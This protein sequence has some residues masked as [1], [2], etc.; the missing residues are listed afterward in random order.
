MRR[1]C[2][3]QAV[4]K[5]CGIRPARGVKVRVLIQAGRV[6]REGA[7]ETGALKVGVVRLVGGGCGGGGGRAY[8]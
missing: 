3:G 8:A 4:D 5:R 6:A 2:Q 1:W 7:V